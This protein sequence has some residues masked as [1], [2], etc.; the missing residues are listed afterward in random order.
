MGLDISP[1]LKY[2]ASVS[3]DR[4]FKLW[5]SESHGGLQHSITTVTTIHPYYVVYFVVS[6]HVIYNKLQKHSLGVYFQVIL[7]FILLLGHLNLQMTFCHFFDSTK[8]T[9]Q[10]L[11]KLSFEINHPQFGH[12]NELENDST[13]RVLIERQGQNG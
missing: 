7:V 4:T 3:Y 9:G 11:M 12:Q 5:T 13:S 6:C 1:D 8:T 2:M 10:V